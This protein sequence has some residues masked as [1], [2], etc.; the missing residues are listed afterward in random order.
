MEW[1]RQTPAATFYRGYL[2]LTIA[3]WSTPGSPQLMYFFVFS[4]NLRDSR[5]RKSGRERIWEG[6]TRKRL[7]LTPT[8][9][10]LSSPH[11]EHAASYR[12]NIRMV[13]RGR[14][15]W[16]EILLV[17]VEK[18][19]GLWMLRWLLSYLN[20]GGTGLFDVSFILYFWWSAGL[21]EEQHG[22]WKDELVSWWYAVI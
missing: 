7:S 22:R 15:G 3:S 17:Y 9:L 20:H 12:P 21:D 10:L 18:K 13:N 8:R 4:A 1:E 19:P 11:A 2:I 16:E 6:I 14:A 5:I